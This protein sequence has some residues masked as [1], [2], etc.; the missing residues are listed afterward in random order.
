MTNVEE[1]MVALTQK[2]LKSTSF[3]RI[4]LLGDIKN[5]CAGLSQPLAFAK[6]MRYLL[7]KVDTPVCDNDVIAG[8]YVDKVLTQEE[9]EYFQAFVADRENLYHTTIFETGHCTLDWEDLIKSGLPGL[10][11]RA[12]KSLGKHKGDKDKEIFLEGAIVF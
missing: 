2:P 11:A 4:K 7:E 8:R 10:K 9:E 3:Q 5:E 12:E 1:A 6:A